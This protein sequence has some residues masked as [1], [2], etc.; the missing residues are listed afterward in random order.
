MFYTVSILL[1]LDKS[2]I[3]HMFLRCGLVPISISVAQN[4][5]VAQINTHRRTHSTFR[6]AGVRVSLDPTTF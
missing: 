5:A 4:S 1:Q 6:V 2:V 3:A